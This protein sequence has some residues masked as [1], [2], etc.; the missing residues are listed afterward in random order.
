MRW[1]P[2]VAA[3]QTVKNN[4]EEKEQLYSWVNVMDFE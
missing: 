4:E 1:L 2:I 3:S